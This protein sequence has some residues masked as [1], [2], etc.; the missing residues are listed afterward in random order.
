MI[1]LS[2]VRRLVLGVSLLNVFTLFVTSAHAYQNA[3]QT[4]TAVAHPETVEW[5]Y[6]IR[7]GSHDEWFQIFRKYQIAIL[8]KQKQLGYVL[9]YTVWGTRRAYQ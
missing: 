6:R 7:Y 3:Q 5:V 9:D 1:V 8:E 4:S 2:L